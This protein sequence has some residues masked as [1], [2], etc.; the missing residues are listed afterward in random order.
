M[1]FCV[2][3]HAVFFIFYLANLSKERR[4]DPDGVKTL[5]PY[6]IINKKVF[7]SKHTKERKFYKNL[8]TREERD[9][10]SR[11]FRNC[12]QNGTVALTFDDGVSLFIKIFSQTQKPHTE[13]LTY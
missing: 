6:K 12:K 8:R 7:S 1:K 4:F 2:F 11:I 3:N 13:F 10:E 9:V 5:R